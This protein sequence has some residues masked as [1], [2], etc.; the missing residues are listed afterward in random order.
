MVWTNGCLVAGQLIG[1]LGFYNDMLT[2]N[3]RCLLTMWVDM[4]TKEFNWPLYTGWMVWTNGCLVAGQLIRFLVFIMICLLE[5]VGAYVNQGVRLAS[6]HQSY[7]LNGCI[8]GTQQFIANEEFKSFS[9]S[10]T[11]AY[12]HSLN[13]SNS[14]THSLYH[15]HSL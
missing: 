8:T 14:H 12:L 1:F 9:H 4:L 5:M 3:G 7:H 2:R 11:H 6:D 10:L 13:H 15:S